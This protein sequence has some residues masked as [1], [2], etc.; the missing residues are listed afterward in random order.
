MNAGMDSLRPN[1]SD[2]SDLVNQDNEEEQDEYNSITSKII[3]MA[4][5]D[6]D[7]KLITKYF[8]I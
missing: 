7:E 2:L 6:A 3:K 4:N 5:S 8:H 1:I